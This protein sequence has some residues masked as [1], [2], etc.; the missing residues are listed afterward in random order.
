VLS[1]F[2]QEFDNED[3]RTA[4]DEQAG[5]MLASAP[6]RMSANDDWLALDGIREVPADYLFFTREF[7][8]TVSG[9]NRTRRIWAGSAAAAAAVLVLSLPFVY[10]WADAMRLEHARDAYREQA[11]TAAAYEDEILDMEYEW[12]VVYEYPEPDV[13]AILMG[14]NSVIDNSLTSFSLSDSTIE[15]QGSTEDP[16]KLTKLL[17]EQ[18]IFD[19]I[20]QS[21]SISESNTGGGDRFGLRLTLS[22]HDYPEYARKYD[23]R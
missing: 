9:R 3:I 22:G 6:I 8:Q 13:P 2:R 20:E 19:S 11:R 21:R 12:G 18:P 17:L 23:F 15:I 1:A 10:Q 14:L 5:P 4:W 16:E 7:Q